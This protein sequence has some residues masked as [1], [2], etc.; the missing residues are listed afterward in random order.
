MCYFLTKWI[1]T[2]IWGWLHKSLPYL[3]MGSYPYYFMMLL[4]A[5]WSIFIIS[6]LVLALVIRRWFGLGQSII[7]FFMAIH[8][9]VLQTPLGQ[10]SL[11]ELFSCN[12]YI[13]VQLFPVFFNFF[14][15]MM[16]MT[17]GLGIWWMLILASLALALVVKRSVGVGVIKGNK[18]FS[19]K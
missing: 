14:H 13:L 2:K 1:N 4:L 3:H 9:L 10:S 6:S 18:I 12:A 5:F 8:D 19:N 15:F 7:N 16:I 11:L 17:F